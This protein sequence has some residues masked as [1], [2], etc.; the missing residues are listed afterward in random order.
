MALSIDLV[1]VGAGKVEVRFE[2]IEPSAF[3][4]AYAI[5][6]AYEVWDRYR[7]L[8]TVGHSSESKEWVA[9]D[10]EGRLWVGCAKTRGGAA[11]AIVRHDR[12]P[13]FCKD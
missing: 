6:R 3:K 12:A 7:R 13:Q 8:G 1:L 11:D 4:Y 10:S 9:R 2:A 5:D